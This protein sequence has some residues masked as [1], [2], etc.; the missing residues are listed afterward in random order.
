M[1]DSNTIPG[2]DFVLDPFGQ[3]SSLNIY[4]Q[5]TSCYSLPD[6]V[7]YPDLIDVL[8]DGLRRLSANYPWVAGQI[9]KTRT[10]EDDDSGT[11]RIIPSD[12]LPHLAVQ[13]LREDASTP[14][15]AQ[16]KEARFPFSM[17]DETV[18][19]PI[20]TFPDPSMSPI[21]VFAMQATIVNGGF[22]LTFLAHHQVMD[23]TG[24][25]QIM[26]L[27]SKA[28]YGESYT[29]EEFLVG[30]LTRHNII[31]LLD[32]DWKPTTVA[33]DEKETAPQV[34]PSNNED[35]APP[36]PSCSWM[37]LSFGPDQLAAIK[38]M[39]LEAIEDSSTV[40]VS[41]DDSLS[42][43]IWQTVA[44]IRLARFGPT[45]KSTFARA[46][47]PRRFLDIPVTYP[48]LVQNMTYHTRTLQEL[49]DG[50]LGEIASNL[51]AAV[52]PRT[53]TLGHD[54]RALATMLDRAPDKSKL[55]VT[56]ALDLSSDIMLSSWA[57]V[58]SYDLDFN[59][60]LG[61]PEAV[62]RPQFTPVESLVYLMP[63]KADGE[64]VVGLCL[65]DE[66]LNR[67]RADEE[68]TK[69]ASFIG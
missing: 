30:N 65:R 51:R 12:V 46:V 61:K 40:F 32:D 52:D 4:T 21:P 33:Q 60:G 19:A 15:M 44:R 48:G 24:L 5:L 14:T 49:T 8:Q 55:S 2:F 41:T 47:N 10:N 63:K 38:S 43:F 58:E 16:I 3:Q 36:P 56:S 59:L 23:M 50:S 28:C 11:F 66:D 17:L 39:V 69:F 62:R 54:T 27:L 64:I 22:L 20:N 6:T 31:P 57:K 9:V 26:H 68:L 7:S 35:E 29:E 13:D 45:K 25:G 67:L 18:V 37:Y 53:S 42:A 34:K 1:D